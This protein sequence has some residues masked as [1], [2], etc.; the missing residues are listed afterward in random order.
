MGVQGIVFL[1]QGAHFFAQGARFPFRRP[2]SYLRGPLWGR[3]VAQDAFFWL[4]G[5]FFWLRGPFSW[6]RGPFFWL[7]DLFMAQG[8]LFLV[9][10]A[11]FLAQVRG[12]PGLVP[13]LSKI[14]AAPLYACV[15]TL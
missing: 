14:L 2:F 11:P 9:Q 12:P 8:A 13:P 10:G 4:R 3:F 1:A 5:L 15:W 6:I 7:R